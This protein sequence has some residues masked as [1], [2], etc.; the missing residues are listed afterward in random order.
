ML[1]LRM[2]CGKELEV[3]RLSQPFS[4]ILQRPLPDQCFQTCPTETP[5]GNTCW[6]SICL[7]VQKCAFTSHTHTH[8]HAF[9]LGGETRR[10]G[11]ARGHHHIVCK[12][13]GGG[14]EAETDHESYRKEKAKPRD[15]EEGRGP[16]PLIALKNQVKWGHRWPRHLVAGMLWA[17]L[18]KQ[19]WWSVGVIKHCHRSQRERGE[20][21]CRS[22]KWRTGRSMLV[23]F[24]LLDSYIRIT[25]IS[26]FLQRLPVFHFND[27][28]PSLIRLNEYFL[29]DEYLTSISSCK[30]FNK[31]IG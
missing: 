2:L 16:E 12:Q 18:A 19:L 23:K 8:T 27:F 30:P 3:S 21:S 29:W 5:T 4:I 1:P 10:G 13:R 31:S 15:S 6:P 20:W 14:E 22:T 25:L 26:I 24:K 9:S 17:A 11:T 7:C 28:T